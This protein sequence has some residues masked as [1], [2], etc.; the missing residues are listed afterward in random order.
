M[1]RHELSI[2]VYYE[3]VCDMEHS[4]STGKY[5]TMT[6]Y[7]G[8]SDAILEGRNTKNWRQSSFW[9]RRHQRMIN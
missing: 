2:N 3:H 7:G 8:S 9:L 1:L 6:K 5:D 4:L